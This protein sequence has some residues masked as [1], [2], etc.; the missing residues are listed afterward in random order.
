MITRIL[1]VSNLNTVKSFFKFATNTINDPYYILGVQ[2]TA[3]MS[4]IKKAF[5][6]L[7][8]EYHPDKVDGDVT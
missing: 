8:N 3:E 6:K 2:K 7:A 4:E 5:Y 1:K